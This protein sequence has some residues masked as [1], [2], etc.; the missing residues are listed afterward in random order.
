M[1]GTILPEIDLLK[2]I[3]PGHL[4]KQALSMFTY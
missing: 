2:V 1:I 4:I 3:Q